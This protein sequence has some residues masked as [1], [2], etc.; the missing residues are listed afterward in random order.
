MKKFK[1]NILI[2]LITGILILFFIEGILRSFDYPDN[3]LSVDPF[4]G[5]TEL[6]PLFEPKKEEDGKEVFVTTKKK[7][8]F[9][10]HQKFAKIKGENEVRIFSFGGSSTYGRPYNA[11]SA[12]P[13]FIEEGLSTI[14]PDKD[15]KVINIGGISYA[16]YRVVSLMMEMLKYK[17]DLFIVYSGHNEFLEERTYSHLKNISEFRKKAQF[18][19]HKL[20]IY[21]VIKKYALIAKNKMGLDVRGIKT[22]KETLPSEVETMLDR[23]EGLDLY[24][25]DFG[26]KEE[27]FEH[28]KYNLERMIELASSAGVPIIL[29][30]LPSNIEDLSPFKSEPSNSLSRGEKG[31]LKNIKVES[32]YLF[33]KGD[34]NQALIEVERGLKIDPKFSAL[35]YLKGK[36]LLEKGLKKEAKKAL[37]LARD[38]DMVPIR[39]TTRINNIIREVA[40]KEGPGFVDIDRIFEE[41]SVDGIPGDNLFMDHCH[42]TIEGH[43]LIAESLLDYMFKNEI[44]GDYKPYSRNKILARYKKIGSLLQDSYFSKGIANVGRVLNWAKKYDES[45]RRLEK[46]VEKYPNDPVIHHYLGVAKYKLGDKERALQEFTR[47]LEIDPKMVNSQKK[48]VEIF[49]NEGKNEKA[50]NLLKD[51]INKGAETSKIHFSLALAYAN[52]KKF[53]LAEKEYKEALKGDPKSAEIYNNLGNLYKQRGDKNHALEMYKKATELNPNLWNVYYNMGTYYYEMDLFEE[54]ELQFRKVVELKPD[55]IDSHSALADIYDKLGD[56]ELAEKKYNDAL[57]LDP[58]SPS[59]HRDIGMFYSKNRMFKEALGELKISLK[60]LEGEEINIRIPKIERADI[61]FHFKEFTKLR[62]EIFNVM[63]NIYYA[64]RDFEKALEMYLNVKKINSNFPNISYNAGITYFSMKKWEEAKDMLIAA[65]DK[66]EKNIHSTYYLAIAQGNLGSLDESVNL[67]KEVISLNPDNALAYKD[68]GVL[69]LYKLKD[70]KSGIEYLEKSLQ[71]SPDQPEA[72]NIRKTLLNL[73]R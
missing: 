45:V 50:V 71:L 42:P 10:N 46:G 73:K 65:K 14:A 8:K 58:S 40:D 33:S 68:L 4:I 23:E 62:A 41:K 29:L 72:E 6:Y 12:F 49:I 52:M 5:F 2:P 37:I 9:F 19:L 60:L 18:N 54:A 55:N 64:S 1:L 20:N 15:Y 67:L 11:K 34:L 30:T 28:F 26:K 3:S 69:Y 59:A 39:A 21:R 44:A 53:D 16:S 31:I 35:I 27:I 61:S 48:I 51:I 56:F 13:R 36:I 63:G 7:E 70:I 57:D 25:Y 38:T 47:A 22:G 43:M 24:T 32:K 17:P 66:N